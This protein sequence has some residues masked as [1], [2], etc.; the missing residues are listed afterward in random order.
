MEVSKLHPQNLSVWRLS[1]ALHLAYS[2]AKC[3]QH[4]AASQIRAIVLTMW[5][6]C[7]TYKITNQLLMVVI[8]S[9][10]GDL[11]LLSL[12]VLRFAKITIIGSGDDPFISRPNSKIDI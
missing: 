7:F 6:Q 3:T 12:L 8:R 11:Y 10:R 1:S 2:Y 5:H 4:L 9:L